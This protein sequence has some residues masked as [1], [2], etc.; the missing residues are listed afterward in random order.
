MILLLIFIFLL[1]ESLLLSITLFGDYTSLSFSNKNDH[2]IVFSEHYE[3][4][5]LEGLDYLYQVI[6]TLNLHSLRI[7][8]FSALFILLEDSI[9]MD[10]VLLMI[11][12]DKFKDQL[13]MFLLDCMTGGYS[14]STYYLGLTREQLT[15]NCIVIYFHLLGRSLI[16]IIMLYGS[17]WSLVG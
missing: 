15:D 1:G 9:N 13:P 4:V 14:R 12:T 8:I 6:S 2:A 16:L 17:I 11:E 3:I 7:L 10:G 5:I